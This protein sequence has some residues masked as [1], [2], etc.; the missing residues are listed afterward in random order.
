MGKDSIIHIQKW[1]PVSSTLV[2]TPKGIPLEEMP[3]QTAAKRKA[4]S[5]GRDAERGRVRSTGDGWGS[6]GALEFSEEEDD[7]VGKS[8]APRRRRKRKSSP[9]DED[10][11]EDRGQPKRA[12][13]SVGAV[14]RE[15]RRP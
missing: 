4:D 6:R 8:N 14:S 7:D 3:A 9:Q 10:S 15:G 13:G 5:R 11:R 1:M 2:K 12:R